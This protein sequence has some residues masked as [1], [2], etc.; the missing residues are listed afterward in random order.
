MNLNKNKSTPLLNHYHQTTT[1]KQE[2]ILPPQPANATNRHGKEKKKAAFFLCYF[3]RVSIW[4]WNNQSPPLAS[5]PQGKPSQL[6]SYI[7]RKL[8][9]DFSLQRRVELQLFSLPTCLSNNPVMHW[10]VFLSQRKRT[11]SQILGAER[12]EFM[13]QG[14]IENPPQVFGQFLLQWEQRRRY[15]VVM[16]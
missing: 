4:Q 13:L 16:V 5:H 11:L 3:Y 6:N 12:L 1:M 7:C 2:V 10:H 9:S 8:T 14:S 15:D